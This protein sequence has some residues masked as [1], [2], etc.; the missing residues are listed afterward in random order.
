MEN[1]N[2][3]RSYSP[4]WSRYA[5]CF[6]VNSCIVCN[7][8]SGGADRL[9]AAG[10]RIRSDSD[11]GA[12]EG[13]REEEREGWREWGR[14]ERSSRALQEQTAP[15]KPPPRSLSPLG[16]IYVKS[17]LFHLLVAADCKKRF[18]TR[19]AEVELMNC[20]ETAFQDMTVTG[21]KQKYKKRR[22]S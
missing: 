17:F 8:S 12:D 9:A 20:I 4:R 15:L 14:L 7:R 13:G 11:R 1:A 2:R 3:L 21:Q 5:C 18:I 10:Q 19:Y 6:V 22:I 16:A